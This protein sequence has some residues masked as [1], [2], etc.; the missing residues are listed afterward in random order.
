MELLGLRGRPPTG[1]VASAIPSPIKRKKAKRER[2][3]KPQK[4]PPF[5]HAL[6]YATLNFWYGIIVIETSNYRKR[7]T[8]YVE[9]KPFYTFTSKAFAYLIGACVIEVFS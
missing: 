2:P 3:R 4:A 7:E 8:D 6:R 1:E 9:S 5:A